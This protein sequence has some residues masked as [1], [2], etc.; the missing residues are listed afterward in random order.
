MLIKEINIKFCIVYMY[1]MIITRV[2]RKIMRP[3][4]SNDTWFR[5]F[6]LLVAIIYMNILCL[7]LKSCLQS[8]FPI[9]VDV[10]W[11][12]FLKLQ[13]ACPHELGHA[14]GM[15]HGHQVRD[16]DDWI[17][18]NTDNIAAGELPYEVDSPRSHRHCS[19]A[20][21]LKA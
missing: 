21:V 7:W 1:S 16:R 9:N 15:P 13:A 8:F 12:F 18:I 19:L 4:F 20:M 5:T 11:L 17:R 14:L 3:Y 10:L 6:I 2:T